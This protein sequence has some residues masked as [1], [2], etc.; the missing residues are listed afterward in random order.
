MRLHG[1]QRVFVAAAAC[2]AH[3]ARPIE[4]QFPDSTPEHLNLTTIASPSDPTISI[5]YKVPEGACKT[6]FDSQ[7][8]YTGWVSIPGDYPTNTF[9]WFIE[10]RDAKA[11]STLT[12]WLNG[13]PGSSSMFGLFNENGPCEVIENGTSR[14]TTA[15]REWGWDRA[16]N[17]LFVDQPN[18]VGFS[19]DEATAGS[20]DLMTNRIAIP[21]TTRPN[22]LPANVFLNGTFSSQNPLHTSNTTQTSATAIWHMLQGFLSTF[23]QYRPPA[24]NTLGVNLFAESYGGKYGPAFAEKW[25]KLNALQPNSTVTNSTTSIELKALGIVNGCVDDLIQGPYYPIMATKNSYG[26]AAINSVRAQ[27]ANA[28]FYAD[29]GCRDLITQ[30][31]STVLVLDPTNSGTVPDVNQLCAK[32]YSTCNEDVIL[33]YSDSGRS[34]YDIAAL[35]PD[36]FPSSQYIDYLNTPNVQEAMG[37][38]LNYTETNMAVYSAYVNTGDFEREAM[39]PKLA[40]LLASGIRVGFMYGDRDYVCNWYGGEAVSL[41]V[42][43]SVPA[44]APF[45]KAGYAPIIVNDTYIGGVVRQFGNLSFSRVYQ[46]GHFVPAYQPNTAF[47]IFARIIYGT[48][49]STGAQINLSSYNTTG[50]SSASSAMDLPASPDPTCYIRNIAGS[51]NDQEQSAI[52]NG[53]ATFVNGALVT[54]SPTTSIPATTVVM[55]ATTTAQLTGVFTATATPSNAATRGGVS[56]GDI[57]SVV[58]AACAAALLM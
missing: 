58:A 12:V 14:L 27:M 46:A 47:E 23:P 13:G 26:L 11:S 52:I 34:V 24:G 56:K 28:S 9:F 20:L 45:A 32:A 39:V 43:E 25:Q 54:Q 55:T 31:R 35:L 37:T 2:L 16:S 10:G 49:V 44:Y 7:Q 40:N 21:A 18:Q 6:A 50:D 15:A 57:G 38:R 22:S 30:C 36:S 1:P 17:M 19:Y 33:P 48:S 51:C 3:L 42:A 8:Q 41:A 53:K 4:A 29:G 5:S